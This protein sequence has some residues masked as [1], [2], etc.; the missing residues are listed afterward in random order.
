[1]I[2]FCQTPHCEVSS[3]YRGNDFVAYTGPIPVLQSS[4]IAS[5]VVTACICYIA[6]EVVIAVFFIAFIQTV[7][8]LI[9]SCMMSFLLEKN[10]RTLRYVLRST[11]SAP[12]LILRLSVRITSQKCQCAVRSVIFQDVTN[13]VSTLV[14]NVIVC[15]N[16]SCMLRCSN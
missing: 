11:A 14:P 15:I 6:S 12:A 9:F 16:I 8:I 3:L 1:M 2:K 5:H 7:I 4:S 10:P 13:V